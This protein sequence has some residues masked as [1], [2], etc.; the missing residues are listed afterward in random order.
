[1]KA[2]KRVLQW[3]SFPGGS[4]PV[5]L[6]Q[7]SFLD[8][9]IV[10]ASLAGILVWVF[11]HIALAQTV[12]ELPMVFEV[13][14]ISLAEPQSNYLSQFLAKD[15]EP[16]A[17][18]DPR[19]ELLRQY[20]QTKNSPLAHEAEILLKQ[21]HFRLIIGISFAESNFCKYQIMPNNCW[22]IG[23]GNPERYATLADGIVRANEL[24]QK[25][26]DNGMTTPKLMRD[27][28]VGWQNHNWILAVEQITKAL[29][30]SGL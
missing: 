5:T 24:I 4:F 15:V 26:Q 27:T 3:G 29:E 8:R 12:Q 25:Y 13:N 17:P 1:M 30:N 16:P 20:L 9:L 2:S 19:I 18:P 14:N 11:P 28:W 6:D 23:G 7:L 21:F 22:G 10:G